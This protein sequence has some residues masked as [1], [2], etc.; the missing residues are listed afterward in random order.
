MARRSF[1]QTGYIERLPENVRR[2]II[3]LQRQ[4]RDLEAAN[5]DL[6]ARVDALE[7]P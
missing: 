6:E 5:E 7:N 2:A 1:A 4:I 3:D